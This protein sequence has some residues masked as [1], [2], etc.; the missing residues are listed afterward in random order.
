MKILASLGLL[1]IVAAVVVV[2]VAGGG[3]TKHTPAATDASSSTP[4]TSTQT[5]TASTT[6]TGTQ[7]TTGSTPTQ[8]T[9]ADTGPTGK[10]LASITSR[11]VGSG[12]TVRG[13]IA[14]TTGG[15]PAGLVVAGSDAWVVDSK[16]NLLVKVTENGSEV[17][18]KVGS[19]PQDVAI[20]RDHN[21]MWV[22]NQGSNTVSVLNADGKLIHAA[23]PVGQK[24]GPVAAGLGAAWVA[25]TGDDTVTRIDA[26]T[27][28][29]R[30][31]SVR[32]MP[33]AIGTA[34]ARVWVAQADRSL[35]V[36][37]GAGDLSGGVPELPGA[38]TPVAVTASNGEWVAQTAAGGP[39]R[40]AR[41]DPRVSVAVRKTPP[42][43]FVVHSDSPD[44]GADPQDI[45][46]LKNPLM[47]NTFWV[48]S[49]SDHTVRRIGTLKPNNLKVL[50]KIPVGNAPSALAVFSRVVWVTDP[51]AKALYEIT[52]GS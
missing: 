41:I 35:T 2:I 47:D 52:Y 8:T 48:V 25:N 15:T 38:G 32:A 26:S 6:S 51:G 28:A 33:T 1:V 31:I 37:S 43:Q 21:L 10:P 14:L 27:F 34:F 17:R 39:G 4:S 5:T 45:D 46:A 9:A 18:V 3:S 30:T 29:T 16:N 11:N 24:P 36:L 12:M 50:A 44:A 7:T 20:D 40:L 19:D 49:S 22:T 42:I 13:P 23:I